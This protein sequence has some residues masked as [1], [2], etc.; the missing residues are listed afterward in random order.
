MDLNDLVLVSVDD[1]VC[2]PPDMFEAHVPARYRDLAPRVVEQDAVQRWWYGDIPGRTIGTN[3]V[4]GKSPDQYNRDVV[5]FDDMRPGCYDVHSRVMDLNV[6][7]VLGS[8]NFPTWTGFCGQILN[9]GPDADV[10]EVMIR[11]YN[12]W[13]VD[14]WCGAYP[15][16]FIPSGIVPYFDAER[17]AREVRRLAAKGCRA[18]VFSEKPEALGMPSIY[19]DYWDPFFAACS[20]TGAIVC[21]HLGSSSVPLKF[22]EDAPTIVDAAMSP[23]RSMY[24]LGEILW[25]PF[26]WRFPDVKVSITEGDIGWMPYFVQRAVY[27]L[28]RHSGWGSHHYPRGATPEDLFRERILCC[29]ID[30]VV[31]VEMLDR[32]N[33]DNLCW[34]LDYP[35]SDSAWPFAPETVVSNVESLGPEVVDKITHL[36][37]MRHYGFDPFAHRSRESCTVGALRAL[38][39]DVDTGAYGVAPWRATTAR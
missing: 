38:A 14:E 8:L 23:V 15:D 19:S 37:A 29:F 24:T 2:E 20:D 17:A 11:A 34:E 33:V 12:D 18:V 16:R 4:A 25:A 1:H 30:D 6:A 28:D 35:H 3:A 31:G 7:G 27:S 5:R 22:A 32:F 10:N 36:N 13:L 26:W 9:Q 21:L 39:E